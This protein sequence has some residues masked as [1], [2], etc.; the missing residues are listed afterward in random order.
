MRV[1]YRLGL[2]LA[3]LAAVAVF[4][5]QSER[6]TG[7]QRAEEVRDAV[8]LL[9]PVGDSGVSG[10]LTLI[11]DGDRVRMTGTITGLEPGPHGFHV[12]EYGDLTDLERGESVG[13]HYNP[14]NMPHGRPED[15]QR[16][17]GDL[18]NITADA[19]GRAQVDIE[20]AVLSLTGSYS[21]VGRALV[22][23]SEADKFTQPSGDAGGRVAF[24]VIGIAAPGK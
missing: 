20:D 2:L 14:T 9:L 1:F 24:G 21:I 5:L 4:A 8:V 16:H 10:M 12:H 13:G 7:A 15:A 22:V 11:Q 3:S 18:G 17:V 19:Q 6:A 23:H